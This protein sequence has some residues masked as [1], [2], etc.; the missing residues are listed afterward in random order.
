MKSHEP[1]SQGN[2]ALKCFIES[3]LCFSILVALIILLA[4][5]LPSTGWFHSRGS[6]PTASSNVP[7]QEQGK[8]G[9][10]LKYAPYVISPVGRQQL[11]LDVE[12]AVAVLVVTAILLIAFVKLVFTWTRDGIKYAKL[13]ITGGYSEEI[14]FPRI[15]GIP[16]FKFSIFVLALT[17]FGWI[18][19]LKNAN[20]LGDI[21]GIAAILGLA[22]GLGPAAAIFF[23]VKETQRYKRRD[24]LSPVIAQAARQETTH[25]PTQANPPPESPSVSESQNE[26]GYELSAPEKKQAFFFVGFIIFGIGCIP[27]LLY[28]FGP[29]PS[30]HTA[31]VL[32]TGLAI[33]SVGGASLYAGRSRSK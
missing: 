2:I 8:P 33:M 31:G 12:I 14:R 19:L 25:L 9:D 29:D 20:N 7:V 23:L 1:T 24:N 3:A 18:G 17:L 5:F 16:F 11:Q 21:G 32:L 22:S 26:T 13:G 10:A 15:E 6:A 27:F 4:L 30:T 28:F